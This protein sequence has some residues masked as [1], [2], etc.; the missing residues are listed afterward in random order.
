VLCAASIDPG[1]C[2]KA[3]ARVRWAVVETPS[4]VWRRLVR[5]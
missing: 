4:G 5:G 2:L 3:L 1:E